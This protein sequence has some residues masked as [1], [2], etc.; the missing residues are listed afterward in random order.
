MTQSEALLRKSGKSCWR[1]AIRRMVSGNYARSISR[2]KLIKVHTRIRAGC[3]GR[4]QPR[5]SSGMEDESWAFPAEEL[6]GQYERVER[7]PLY[8]FHQ[9]SGSVV[10]QPED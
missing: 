5:V 4:L 1:C 7:R 10:E 6:G 2:V 9:S 8:G 3:A